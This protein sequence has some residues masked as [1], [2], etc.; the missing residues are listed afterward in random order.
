[1]PLTSIKAERAARQIVSACKRG[2]AE[3]VISIQAKAAVLCHSLFPEVTE[4]LL[5]LANMMLP[6]PGG[7]GANQ[8]KGHDSTSPLSPSWLTVLNERAALRNNEVS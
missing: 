6:G 7:I 1:M 5:A 4:D 2:Q 3:L 8:A